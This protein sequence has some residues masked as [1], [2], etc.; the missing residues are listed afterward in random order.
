[1]N[2]KESRTCCTV[3]ATYNSHLHKRNTRGP[4]LLKRWS[5]QW[6][7]VA[8]WSCTTV[9][10]NL[11]R[12]KNNA[13]SGYLLKKRSSHKIYCNSVFLCLSP[14]CLSSLYLGHV[15]V[16]KGAAFL[17]MP[18][19]FFPSLIKFWHQLSQTLS[20]SIPG[21]SK[22]GP[23]G[24]LS[25]RFKMFP[26]FYTPDSDEMELFKRLLCSAQAS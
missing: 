20:Q 19:S 7:T 13:I 21:M 11:K 22:V 3:M 9:A 24:P 25:C 10:K 26:R 14:N 12:Q 17:R 8:L 16:L 4:L 15:A 6:K 18:S 5:W 23:R 1:M 2:V